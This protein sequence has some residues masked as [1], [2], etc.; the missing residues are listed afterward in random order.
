MESPKGNAKKKRLSSQSTLFLV[1][2]TCVVMFVI[3]GL[4]SYQR[5]ERSATDSIHL[6]EYE[7]L[8]VRAKEL[9]DKYKNLAG[10][11]V[12]P[13]VSTSAGIGH[14]RSLDKP[15]GGSVDKADLV[16]GMAQDTDPK[17]LVMSYIFMVY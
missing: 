8:L 7:A 17:N 5:D 2:V 10:T 1:V 11:I 3:F 6:R 15:S 4:F 16:L 9:T 14:L 12:P 13:T